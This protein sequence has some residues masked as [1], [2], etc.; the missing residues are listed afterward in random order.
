MKYF[1]KDCSYRGTSSGQDGGCLAC[2]SF[3][4]VKVKREQEKPPGKLRLV[5][6]IVLWA[7]LIGMI[8][9]KLYH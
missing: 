9:W 4:L 5:L 8:I 7:Y 1:C 2:G 3:N 6:L